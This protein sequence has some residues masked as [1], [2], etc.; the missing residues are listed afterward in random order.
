M[1]ALATLLAA[2]ASTSSVGP[3]KHCEPA[4]SDSVRIPILVYHDVA[5]A[6]APQRGATRQFNVTPATFAAQMQH[7]HERRVQVISLATL[8]EALEQRCALPRNAVVITFDDGRENQYRYAFPV[9]KRHGFIATFFPFTHAMNR[10][11]RYLTWDQLREMQA[12]GMTI[13]SHAHLHPRMDKIRDPELMRRE[14]A[15]SREILQ[16]RLA[17]GADLFAYPFG[18]SSAEAERAVRDAGFRAARTFSGGAWNSASTLYRLR[19]IPVT[20]NMRRFRSIIDQVVP[21]AE[22]TPTTRPGKP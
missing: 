20:E 10:N 13:G 18:A 11:P 17:S 9:L 22:T 12:A 3:V 15:G 19:A 2:L 21:V 7:L 16:Q 6:D 14:T 8:V 4:E 1:F 5:P